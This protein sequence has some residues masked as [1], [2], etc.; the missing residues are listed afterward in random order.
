MPGKFKFTYNGVTRVIQDTPANTERLK[1]LHDAKADYTLDPIEDEADG[2]EAAV[3]KVDKPIQA[4]P[5]HDSHDVW[6]GLNA[7]LKN[8][9]GVDVNG[10]GTSLLDAARGIRKGSTL[11]WDDELARL[12]GKLGSSLA[13]GRDASNTY[14]GATPGQSLEQETRTDAAES[15]TRSPWLYGAGQLAGGVGTTAALMAPVVGGAGT[16]II[17]RTLSA[18]QLGS[19]VSQL[20]GKLAGRFVTPGLKAGQ[21]AE[22]LAQADQAANGMLRARYGVEAAEGNTA[23]ATSAADKEAAQLASQGARTTSDQAVREA[24]EQALRNMGS[25]Q[26]FATRAVQGQA[27]ADALRAGQ[28]A[29]GAA[30]IGTSAGTAALN[31]AGEARPGETAAEATK[32]LAVG[33]LTQGVLS[34]AGDKL[35]EFA[36][37]LRAAA[38]KMRSAVAAPNKTMMKNL[39]E[40][41]GV[42]QADDVLGGF[43]EKYAPP[44]SHARSADDY[45][46][47]LAGKMGQARK[48]INELDEAVGTQP[49]QKFQWDDEGATQGVP[50]EV[51]T[52][53]TGNDEVSS[54]WSDLAKQSLKDAESAGTTAS[55]QGERQIAKA[56][57]NNAKT[58][59]GRSE[60]NPNEIVV[61]PATAPTNLAALR[62]K[63][64]AYGEDAF[65]PVFARKDGATN[66]AALDLWKRTKGAQ[67]SVYDQHAT[68]AQLDDFHGTNKS[69]SEMKALEEALKNVSAGEKSGHFGTELISGALTGAAGGGLTGVTGALMTGQNP[70]P[71]G[72]TGA[73][74]G[75]LLNTS[76]GT[77]SIAKRYANSS[78]MKD[79][80]ANATRGIG[81]YADRLGEKL[82]GLTKTTATVNT[83]ARMPGSRQQQA[84]EPEAFTSADRVA[85]A[86]HF[87]PESLGQ[88]APMLLPFKDDPDALAREI[89][90]LEQ[91]DQQGE[92]FRTLPAMRSNQ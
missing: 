78:M 51:P 5:P 22:Q 19:K 70:I 35:Q 53:T 75:A 31:R 18:P 87:S 42:S 63:T 15:Q 6:A 83:L 10:A 91:D 77:N 39:Q 43:I 80:Y 20:A 50:R 68:P 3:P 25:G 47:I 62:G 30:A 14:A 38:S 76:T 29:K 45:I 92:K 65:G 86:L 57:M 21:T 4:P 61:N 90:R 67:T 1:Q 49:A 79:R 52:P 88:F 13:G 73:L 72:I 8:T 7:G 60:S 55:A 16:G 27:M 56:K 48:G 66:Q 28:Y 11:G 12:G 23:L 81:D 74:S 32:G 9:Y 33:A 37:G 17:G 36:P 84:A 44:S 82:T 54:Q 26:P 69:F 64:Q 85:R 41:Y 34:K 59:A 46:S 89:E 24:G 71:A 58:I 40:K 2:N